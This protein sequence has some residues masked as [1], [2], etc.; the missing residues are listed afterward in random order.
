MRIGL[1][2]GVGSGATQAAKWLEAK[3]ISVLSGDEAGHMALTIPEIKNSLRERFGQRV[4]TDQGEVDRPR[5]GE[6]IFGNE[7][8]RKNLDRIVHPALLDILTRDARRV[9]AQSGVVV[10]DA[11]LI[12]EWGLAGFFHR[13]IVVDAPLDIRIQRAMARDGLSEEQIRQRIAAQWPLEKKVEQADYVLNNVG[14]LEEL[15]WQMDEVWRKL[16]QPAT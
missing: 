8:A 7:E 1:T 6:I 12:Y 9:E 10:V 15:H 3:G 13:I 16:E 11:A 14:S 2:G 4:F 5:L